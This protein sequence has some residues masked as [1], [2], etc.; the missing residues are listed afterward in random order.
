LSDSLKSP[1]QAQGNR[2]A[3]AAPRASRFRRPVVLKAFSLVFVGALLGVPAVS[4]D[5]WQPISP[6]ELKMTSLPEAP[7]APAVILYRQVDR[8]DTRAAPNFRSSP[9]ATTH[10]AGAGRLV[11]QTERPRPRR[12]L[13][14][15]F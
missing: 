14:P 3:T 10:C 1:S 4:A 8:D 15:I 9:I 5:D 6:D 7:D 13:P 11:C 2:A 12:S